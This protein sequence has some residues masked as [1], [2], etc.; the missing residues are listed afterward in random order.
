MNFQETIAR[1]ITTE[2]DT[3]RLVILDALSEYPFIP[4]EWLPILLQKADESERLTNDILPLIT[5]FPVNNKAF[6]MIVNRLRHAEKDLQKVWYRNLLLNAETE[7]IADNK[8]SIEDL[9]ENRTFGEIAAITQL[10]N[11]ALMDQLLEHSGKM[12]EMSVYS[13]QDFKLGKHLA[14]ELLNRDLITDE[15]IN[16]VI[17]SE[18]K[19]E[20]FSFHG[21]YYIYMIGK[22]KMDSYLPILAKLLLRTEEDILMD[23]ASDALIRLHS[24][25]VVRKVTHYARK[26][27]SAIYAN[28]ILAN[29]KTP[30]ARKKLLLLMDEPIEPDMKQYTAEALCLSSVSR[31]LTKNKRFL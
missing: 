27:E 10:S 6:Q 25:D 16:Q 5:H 2:D 1:F 12:E 9:E 23:Q 13:H 26:A 21:M 11:E 22:K 20:W 3:V 14:D 28:K 7:M 29:I 24:D 18:L 4:D 17:E 8:N 30:L 19:Q 15:Q 31:R